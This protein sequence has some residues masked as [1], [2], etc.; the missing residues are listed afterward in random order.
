MYNNSQQ[1]IHQIA[2]NFMV[3]E[4]LKDIATLNVDDERNIKHLLDIYVGPECENFLINQPS[5]F[6]QE[7]K[8]TC[9]NFYVTS[10]KEMLK[11][12]RIKIHFLKN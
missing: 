2:Q 3:P 5:A 7:I 12:C 9:L 8:L 1:I 10:L 11:R 6:V 4:A